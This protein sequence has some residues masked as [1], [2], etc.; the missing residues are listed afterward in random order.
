MQTQKPLDALGVA[1]MKERAY[2]SMLHTRRKKYESWIRGIKQGKRIGL[3]AEWFAACGLSYFRDARKRLELVECVYVAMRLVDDVVDRD[4]P[5]PPEWASSA[6]Y[7][8]AIIAF[9]D[10]EA[11]Q[12]SPV[13]ELLRY[14]FHIGDE[15]GMDMRHPVRDMLESMAFDAKRQESPKMRTFPREALERHF[16]LLDIRGTIG[17]CLLVAREPASAWKCIEPLGEATRI[18]YTLRDLDEDLRANFCNVPQEDIDAFGIT[19]VRHSTSGPMR[20]WKR[21][22]CLRALDFL[23][24]YRAGQELRSLHPITRFILNRVY[25]VPTKRYLL[26]TLGELDAM[27]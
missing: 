16:H 7:V 9:L 5:L 13:M 21:K 24:A 8:G 27:P 4:A 23:G 12:N 20:R 1:E 22:E 25:E 17:G 19:N 10:G 15:L 14:A 26:R 2:G 18:R 11:S 3:I 6:A